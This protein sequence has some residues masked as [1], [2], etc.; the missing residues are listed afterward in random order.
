MKLCVFESETVCGV[1]LDLASKLDFCHARFEKRPA[2][3]DLARVIG[4]SEGIFCSKIPMTAEVM[5]AC[6][7]LKYIGLTATGYNNIDLAAAKARGITVTNIPAYSTDAVA[8]MTFSFI[9]QFAT[10]LIDYAS[11]TQR[12]DWTRSEFFCYFPYPLTELAGKTLGLLGLGAIGEKVAKIGAAFGMRVIY[13]SRSQKDCPYQWVSREELFR[14]SDFLSLHCP[15]TPETE[16]TVNG[17]SL[18]WM[19][20]SA[21]LVNTSRGGVIEE[22][23]LA[24]ALNEER[25]A[26][27]AADVL[28]TEP[29]S[30]DCPLIGAKNCILTPHVAWA[31]KE[32]RIRLLGILVE[33]LRSY[34]AGTPKNVVNP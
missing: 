30:H 13:H 15:L 9:L 8:Q 10:S 24:R 32:T 2:Q 25:I 14:Q 7:N 18:G 4:D 3:D 12:G 23:A 22:E 21:Y 34:L 27:F 20:K 11:S 1:D 5:D 29:Q 28:T 16:K 33:N 17:E 19:K 6:P 26:G 31:P